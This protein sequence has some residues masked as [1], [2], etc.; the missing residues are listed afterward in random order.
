MNGSTELRGEVPRA[1]RTKGWLTDLAVGG[2]GGVLVAAVVAV[3]FVI[4]I[5]V[6]RGYESSLGEVFEHSLVAGIVTVLI[7]VTGPI[8]GV[9]TAR[10]RRAR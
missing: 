4:F 6:E 1:E 5:G 8:V 7:L 2:I 9:L 10:R 3:N